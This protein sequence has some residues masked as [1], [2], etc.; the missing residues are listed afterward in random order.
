M[1]N[2]F[3][4]VNQIFIKDKTKGT[5]INFPKLC[6]GI[7][8]TEIPLLWAVVEVKNDKCEEKSGE[9]D[10]CFTFWLTPPR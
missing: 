7:F 4:L 8:V 3:Y 2:L 9:V 1:I 5:L 6:S 10:A